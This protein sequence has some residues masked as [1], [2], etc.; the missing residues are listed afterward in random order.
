MSSDTQ[1][2]PTSGTQERPC[3]WCGET[4]L[5]AAKKCRHCKS[6][7]EDHVGTRET[8]PDT[9]SAYAAQ[10]AAP[11]FAPERPG[12]SFSEAV[13][14]GFQQALNFS[15]RARRSEFW[16]WSLFGALV[17]FGASVLGGILGGLT[18]D[19]E[20]AAVAGMLLQWLA[21]FALFIPYLSVAI[22]RLH[23][24]NKSG[25]WYLLIFTV[26]GAF[27]VFYWFCKKGTR[28]DNQFGPSPY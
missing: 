28:G 10:Y 8:M 4:I 7:I 19:I 5:V 16:Y 13:K 18:G 15:G 6:W 20:N 1:S 3:P 12:V 22:R 11:S 21:I 25:W 14:R 23:D 2:Q 17:Q 9:A 24:V 27:V 26:I